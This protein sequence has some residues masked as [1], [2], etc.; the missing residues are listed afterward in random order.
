MFLYILNSQ[1]SAKNNQILF[2][3]VTQIDF[4]KTHPN[5]RFKFRDHLRI[6][7]RFSEYLSKADNFGQKKS[8][9]DRQFSV[10]IF[11]TLTVE[12][13]E[14]PFTS[15][16]YN[17]KVKRNIPWGFLSCDMTHVICGICIFS[18]DIQISGSW[19]WFQL[20]S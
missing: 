6:S 11:R 7:N 9:V 15:V 10:A 3:G 12:I 20:G 18:W 1:I 5:T 4:L 16:A 19:T 2:L 17:L 8:Q 14:R 13:W